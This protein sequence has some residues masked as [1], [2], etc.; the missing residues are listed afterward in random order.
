MIDESKLTFLYSKEKRDLVKK[1]EYYGIT[2]L[3]YLIIKSGKEK[4]RGYSGNLSIEEIQELNNE[5]SLEL[6]G[7]YL[8][9]DY[10]ENVRLSFD[11][12]QALKHQITKN[13]LELDDKQ[14]LEFM[15]GR[16]ILL[17]KEEVQKFEKDGETKGFKV[18]KNKGDILGIGKLVEGRI[19]NYMPKERRLR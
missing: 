11:A 15:K 9:N 6:V 7:M 12:V 5:L 1:L 3:P 14:A 18:I 2:E 13:I 8:F 10:D 16:D 4:L 19:V 17:S